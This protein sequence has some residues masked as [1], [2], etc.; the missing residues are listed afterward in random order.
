[1]YA[2]LETYDL[3]DPKCKYNSSVRENF[4]I[5]PKKQKKIFIDTPELRRKRR[6]GK[7]IDGMFCQPYDEKYPYMYMFNPRYNKFPYDPDY[8]V[9]DGQDDGKRFLNVPLFSYPSSDSTTRVLY[10]NDPPKMWEF[11]D[12]DY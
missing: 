2:T 6:G 5:T 7:G 1:M 8:K 11:C 3:H 9:V 4:T 10:C 12:D